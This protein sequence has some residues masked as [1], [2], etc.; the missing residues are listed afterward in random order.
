MSSL[1]EEAPGILV[2]VQNQTDLWIRVVVSYRGS[3]STTENYTAFVAPRRKSGQMLS[4]PISEITLGDVQNLEATGARV[5]LA[6]NVTDSSTLDSFPYI[7]VDAFGVLLQDEV[8]YECGDGI[9]FTVQASS[10]AASGYQTFAYVRPSAASDE[11]TW[12]SGDGA[13]YERLDARRIGSIGRVDHLDAVGRL[14][15]QH[16]A[17]GGLRGRDWWRG[18]STR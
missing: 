5:F 3:S 10:L 8:D 4:C 15:N 6:D 13:V 2:E 1:P 14:P 11:S 18:C 12:P 7:E 9:L 16:P 17:S